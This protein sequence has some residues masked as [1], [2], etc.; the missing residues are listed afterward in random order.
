MREGQRRSRPGGCMSSKNADVMD[1]AVGPD[2][3]HWEL[4]NT[5][6]T[7]SPCGQRAATA[8][9]DHHG[10]AAHPQHRGKRAG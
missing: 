2:G 4:Q 3:I 9:H 1:Y 8:I 7:T 10:A 6:V 5:T